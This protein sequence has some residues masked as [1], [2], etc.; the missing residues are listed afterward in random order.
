MPDLGDIFGGGFDTSTHE[1]LN[2]YDLIPPGKYIVHID[3]AEVKQ[4][5][6]GDGYYLEIEMII[7]DGPC[8]NRK[9]WDRIN[10]VNPSVQCQEIGLRAL[11]ALGCAAGITKLNL[12][13]QLVSCTVVAHVKVK[14]EQN[15]IRTYSSLE[16][17]NTT[18]QQGQPQAPV[19]P[20]QPQQASTSQA[21][22]QQASAP[23]ARPF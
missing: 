10:I 13:A 18:Q 15:E 1:P 21:P 5:K 11:T 17:C 9:L 16:K 8:K 12:A 7:M 6:K 2:D 22:T 20:Q 3:R 19:Q 14:K 4:T 23:W